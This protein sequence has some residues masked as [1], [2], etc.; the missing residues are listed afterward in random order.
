MKKSLVALAVLGAFAGVAQAQVTLNGLVD[1][2]I[3]IADDGDDRRTGLD[4]GIGAASRWGIR[5][6]E[7]LGG[8]LKGHFVLES[9]FDAS[10]GEGSN[11]FSRL[12]YLGLDGGFGTVRLGRQ[13]TA[14]KD[15]LGKID[16]FGAAGIANAHDYFLNNGNYVVDPAEGNP[17][18]QRR[19][20]Q[21]TY[22]TPN[23]GGFNAGVY[24]NF[25]EEYGDSSLRQVIGLRVGYDT[26]PLSVQLAH[27]NINVGVIGGNPDLDRDDTI[28]GVTYD[29]SVAK[30]HAAYGNR[31]DDGAGSDARSGMVG[32][33]APLGNGKIIAN[34]I[35]IENRDV[36]NADSNV[37]ALGYNYSLSKRTALI[38]RYVRTDN[39]AG[40][41]LA[42]ADGDYRVA[43]AGEN[44]NAFGLGIQHRF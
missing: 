38:A 8:G 11:T 29:F 32:V 27:E 6:S 25:G 40:A 36:D 10:T 7:D 16:P 41:S 26:G 12:A 1:A 35:H 21:L 2:G 33:S 28:L 19:P 34:Y 43:R 44:A 22:L 37:I 5:G 24:Y 4:S 42:I 39:D 23:F 20:N 3:V 14:M 18:A 17:I 15:L 31:S 9:G 30:L 13:D